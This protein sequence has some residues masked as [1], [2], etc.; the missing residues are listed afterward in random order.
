MLAAFECPL[1]WLSFMEK[2]LKPTVAVSLDLGEFEDAPTTF[3]LKRGLL[4][5]HSLSK[6]LH[7]VLMIFGDWTALD[8][9][10]PVE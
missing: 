7:E 6:V 10:L 2:I 5:G 8:I 4:T 9:H 3:T 1:T